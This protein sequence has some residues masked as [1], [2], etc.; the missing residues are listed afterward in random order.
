[1]VKRY[2][3][4]EFLREIVPERITV[5]KAKERKVALEHAA[6]GAADSAAG[7]EGADTDKGAND[8]VPS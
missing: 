6:G 3:N 1:M 4:L 8:A 5:R 2:D 7:G